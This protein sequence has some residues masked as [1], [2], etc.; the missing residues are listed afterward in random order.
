MDWPP[1]P[2]DQDRERQR[3]NLQSPL[4]LGFVAL[5]FEGYNNST[6]SGVNC[7][8]LSAVSGHQ[9]KIELAAIASRTMAKRPVAKALRLGVTR[10]AR[11][12]RPS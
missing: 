11:I 12:K 4:V 3:P 10:T 5:T 2:R 7:A 1:I 9:W 6:R 8:S